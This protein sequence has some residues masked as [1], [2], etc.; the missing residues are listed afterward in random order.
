MAEG[1]AAAAATNP[2]VQIGLFL[3]GGTLM[4]LITANI[5]GSRTA[6][7][8]IVD[9][10]QEGAELMVGLQKKQDELCNR[11]ASL[12]KS[13]EEQIQFNA[14]ISAEMARIKQVLKLN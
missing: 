11:T 7:E 10:L 13:R 2:W 14:N 5:D 6:N 1:R 3:T 9:R 12:E 4:A 8:K